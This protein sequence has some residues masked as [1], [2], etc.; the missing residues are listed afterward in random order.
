MKRNSRNRNT[1]ESDSNPA[2]SPQ[3]RMKQDE[4]TVSSTDTWR[5]ISGLMTI[6]ISS[7]PSDK[8][9]GF[10]MDS[11]L[12]C[13]KSGK[14]FAVNEN[15]WR[16][17]YDQIPETL[18]KYSS[19][20]YR[21]VIFTNQGGVKAGKQDKSALQRK[22][23]AVV[24]A[25]EVPTLVLAAIDDDEFR[26]PCPGMW[27]YFVKNLNG[28]VAPD[29]EQSFYI[30]DAAGRPASGGR[31]K[32]FNDTDLKFA[33]NIGVTFQTPEQFFLGAHENI[34]EVE[35][36]PKLI[37]KEGP[38]LKG[39][40][41]NSTLMKDHQEAIIFVGSP[42]SGKS[43]FW[44]NNLS[45]YVRVNNDT[46]KTKE[47]CMKTM[48]DALNA[49]KS[50]VID[51]TNPTAEVRANYINIAKEFNV[52][53][54]CFLFSMPKEMAFHLDT[55]RLV[56]K[57]RNHLSGRVGSMPI[58]KFYKDFQRPELREGFEEIKEVELVGGPFD[59]E[60]DEKLFFSFVH[61]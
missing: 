4:S 19:D 33:L 17:L 40:T 57:H 49:G 58:H 2:P 5:E 44:K 20:G 38:V 23:E 3:K 45:R 15:D 34:P 35:I 52:P 25:L 39:E 10:D 42:G 12:I 54:R 55:L 18:K 24:S 29:M 27:D 48:R 1:S 61:S 22:I 21:I 53:V 16:L 8:V 28:G 32:D 31:K 50:C 6:N 59:N 56:N 30:G 43:T 9:L 47:K 51:N 41:D 37:K 46:L 11:T 7:S 14:T 13:T 26:K 36:N 60:E